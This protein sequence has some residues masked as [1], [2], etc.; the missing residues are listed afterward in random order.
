VEMPTSSSSFLLAAAAAKRK[1]EDEV[2]ISTTTLQH[3]IPS[4]PLY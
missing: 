3:G 2:G 1:E 4:F